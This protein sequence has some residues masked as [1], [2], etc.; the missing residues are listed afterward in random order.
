MNG[1]TAQQIYENKEFL[2]RGKRG[3]VY[4]SEYKK[5]KYLIKEKN[6][7]STALRTIENETEF[8]QKLNILGVG[9]RFIFMDASGKFLIREFIEGVNIYEWMKNNS[10]KNDFKKNIIKIFSLIF[11]Q[12]RK[13]DEA[14]IN[15]MEMTH[16][17]KDILITKNN[18]P[19]IIDFERCRMSEKPKNVTQFCQFLASGKMH[20]E[21]KKLGI[22]FDKFKMLKA[23][24]EYKKELS[25]EKFKKIKNTL[26]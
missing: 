18:E 5:K 13:M 26:R 10:E 3:F 17:H 12:A 9:P 22:K 20:A 15:K 7:S 4:V 16:P 1:N 14:G 6:P 21:L 24:G 19:V 11:E 8:N 25:E 23:A 2:A